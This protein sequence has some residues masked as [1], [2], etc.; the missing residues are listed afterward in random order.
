MNGLQANLVGM[1]LPLFP[2]YGKTRNVPNHQPVT[3]S[4][5][6]GKHLTHPPPDFLLDGRLLFVTRPRET[7]PAATTFE[8][9]LNRQPGQSAEHSDLQVITD[10]QFHVQNY[11]LSRSRKS[12]TCFLDENPSKLVDHAYMPRSDDHMKG[13]QA[14]SITISAIQNTSIPSHHTIWI[15]LLLKPLIT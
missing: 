5:R 12:G 11:A 1:I 3:K 8:Q 13:A 6:A 15:Y 9:Y 7:K 4:G 10:I 14:A 2:I